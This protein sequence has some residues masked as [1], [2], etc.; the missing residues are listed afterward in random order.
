MG[1]QET[2]LMAAP[3]IVRDGEPQMQEIVVLLHDFSFTP[4]E[5]ILATLKG[6]GAA[7]VGS[8]MAG[9]NMGGMAMGAMDNMD[10]DLNDITF[11]AYLANDRTLSDPEIVAVDKGDTV[12]LRIINAA[13]STNFWVDLGQ[14]EGTVIAVDGM[15][16]QPL[17]GSQFGLTMAQR[18]DIEITIPTDGAVVPVLAQREGDTARTG[19]VLAPTGATITKMSE[20][21]DTNSAPVLLELE[22]QLLAAFPLSAKPVTRQI[23]AMLT[24]DMQAYVWGIDGRTY[25]NRQPLEVAVGERVE[26]TMHNMTMMSHPMHLHGHHFQV[27]GLEGQKIS[28]AMRDT[29]LVPSMGMVTIQ[30]DADNPGEW[31]LHC[32]NLYHMAAGMMTTVKYV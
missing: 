10:M 26:I 32:H 12:L 18:I 5:D 24:G 22:Q 29:V 16:V 14:I 25:D 1:L 31:P 20:T 15:P 19:I 7:G 30:F 17:R 11:D 3:L 9:M 13:A 8:G 2:Q 6:A 23:M 27:V 28:G 4:P 21:A